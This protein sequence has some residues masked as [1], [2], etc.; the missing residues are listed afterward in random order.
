MKSLTWSSNSNPWVRSTS[1]TCMKPPAESASKSREIPWHKHHLSRQGCRIVAFWGVAPNGK[2]GYSNETT[3]ASIFQN[4]VKNMSCKWSVKL[5]QSH[6]RFS[7]IH[8]KSENPRSLSS[9]YTAD[10]P[11]VKSQTYLLSTKNHRPKFWGKSIDT[12]S[13]SSLEDVCF[14]STSISFGYLTDT[15]RSFSNV[16]NG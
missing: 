15:L 12:I 7:F 6:Q 13:S 1:Q 2:V 9:I 8:V 4:A 14:E 10:H 5:R 16:G 3:L 11:S